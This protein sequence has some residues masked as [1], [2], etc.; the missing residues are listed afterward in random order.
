[1]QFGIATSLIMESPRRINSGGGKS[2]DLLVVAAWLTFGIEGV[3]DSPGLFTLTEGGASAIVVFTEGEILQETTPLMVAGIVVVCVNT[4][5]SFLILRMSELGRSRERRR[6]LD[7]T[8]FFLSGK[9]ESV[10][11]KEL[12]GRFRRRFEVGDEDG[13]VVEGVPSNP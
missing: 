12:A 3:I 4:L 1:M 8:S 5:S 13:I 7:P 6:R 9:R 10:G 11:D 2:K